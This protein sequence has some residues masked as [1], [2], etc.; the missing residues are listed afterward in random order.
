[1]VVNDG[2]DAAAGLLWGYDDS[3][4][5]LAIADCVV[6]IGVEGFRPPVT[7]C[8]S[9]CREGRFGRCHVEGGVLVEGELV[10]DV[11]GLSEAERRLGKDK[12][13][14]DLR[15]EIGVAGV[16]PCTEGNVTE[17]G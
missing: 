9:R 12:S 16:L 2:T 6:L 14:N 13:A 1:M 8:K 7:F 4:G 11:D 17:A 3:D 5:T 10:F 15:R